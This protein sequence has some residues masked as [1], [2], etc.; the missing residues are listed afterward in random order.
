[1]RWL[2]LY[3]KLVIKQIYIIYNPKS[4]GNGKRNANKFADR[5]ASRA[6]DLHVELVAT[7][8]AGHSTELAKQFAGSQVMIVSSS[9]DGGFNEL[10]NGAVTSKYPQTVVG[11]LPSGN[12]NDHY[13][14]RH[15]PDVIDR[16]KLSKVAST[17]LLKVE[18]K[19]QTRYAH[20]Y[21]GLGMTATI[22]DTLTK[23]DLNPLKEIWLVISHL[24]HKTPVKI[25][26]DGQDQAYDSLVFSVIGRM[27]KYFT[28]G[29]KYRP[30]D[31][32]FDIIRLRQTSFIGTMRWIARHLVR[33]VEPAVTA[34]QF[35]F[36][37]RQQTTLQLD[38]ET[39]DLA[40]GE[41]VKISCLKSG[42]KYII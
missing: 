34:S 8:H 12:A 27:S 24:F 25:T 15:Q 26:V 1:M 17:D 5:L 11:L 2:L 14:Y 30:A 10:I 31:G 20:A 37:T 13:H 39:V 4:T 29:G 6:P 3:S 41:N 28:I 21:V 35:T 7:T 38:G 19:D 36:T 23:S 16:I 22:G 33:P 9:G 32:T 40:A 18:W 42:L